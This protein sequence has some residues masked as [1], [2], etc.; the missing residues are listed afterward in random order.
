MYCVVLSSK[1]ARSWQ[2]A[3]FACP[4]GT[5]ETETLKASDIPLQ[6]FTVM[7]CVTDSAP[8]GMGFGDKLFRR[9]VLLA[10]LKLRISTGD[11]PLF[12]RTYVSS[13]LAALQADGGTTV[14]RS[15]QATEV[16]LTRQ[17]EIAT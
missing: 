8:A 14:K 3:P 16:S 4:A 1:D 5:P 6:A 15:M 13:K 12:V 11:T 17:L 9:S 2:T 10:P 7:T